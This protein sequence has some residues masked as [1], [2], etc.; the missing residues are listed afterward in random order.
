MTDAS[1]FAPGGDG[2]WSLAFRAIETNA[3]MHWEGAW[4]DRV[5]PMMA[6]R[7]F[8]ALV[9]HQNDLLDELC[10][11][12][13]DDLEGV[14][15]LRRKMV[16]SR[17]S[18]MRRLAR[19]LR[20]Q[21]ADLYLEVKE[22]SYADYMIGLYPDLIDGDGRVDP[23]H[24]LWTDILSR[25]VRAVLEAIPELAGIIVS[26]SSP[27]SRVSPHDY[28]AKGRTQDFDFASWLEAMIDAIAE[29]LEA[30]GKRL[31]VRDFAYGHRAQTDTLSVLRSSKRRLAAALKIT[32]LDY[33]PGFPNNPAIAAMGDVPV[34]VEFEAVGEDTGWGVV[35]NCR[36]AEFVDR[37]RYVRDSG[38]V[39]IMIR[40]NWEGI[41]GWSALDSLSDLNVFVL[42]QLAQREAS[43]EPK[44]LVKTWI[45]E[46]YGVEPRSVLPKQLASAL[47]RSFDCVR[48][49]YWFGNVFPRHSQVPLTWQQ[50]WWSMRHH[51]VAH[52]SEGRAHAN[53]FDLTEANR[54]RLFSAKADAVAL[55]NDLAGEVK[56]L[57]SSGAITDAMRTDF[58]PPF[59][60]LP[61]YMR[62]FE[63]AMQG[64]FF[65]QRHALDHD[66]ADRDAAVAI[67]S[68]LDGMAEAYAAR[69]MSD[70][71][72]PADHVIDVMFDPAHLR[73]FA[74][75]LREIRL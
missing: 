43:N 60:R 66:R 36:A 40:I 45:D 70:A 16:Y 58:G 35:P 62:A 4:L 69:A 27:E 75:S 6:R 11:L 71:K 12:D 31:I 8:N 73:S 2:R 72:G 22:P 7:G 39:G 24:P 55:A 68:K 13:A 32:P 42:A 74:R 51:A 20:K 44:S 64:A 53:D 21:G 34:I 59:S 14:G 61:I 52:W 18:W 54:N 3:P 50:A 28:L 33:F 17:T 56:Q 37:M 57:L 63:L 67:A 46:R 29:P 15:D 25:K 38:A 48:E 47:V 41:I 9:V 26:F 10:H 49:I 30:A 65:A 1:D 23:L 5:L 19:R